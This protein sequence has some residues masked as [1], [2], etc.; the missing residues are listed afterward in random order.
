MNST[1]IH[2]SVTQVFIPMPIKIGEIF[3]KS[4]RPKYTH[5]LHT[6]NESEIRKLRKD[7][8]ESVAKIKRIEDIINEKNSVE[9]EIKLC[10]DK[11]EAFEN[12]IKT[13]EKKLLKNEE[14]IENLLKKNDYEERNSLK[15]KI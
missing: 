13:L 1:M 11:L 8:L 3:S 15:K 14:K 10:N 2:L 7:H 12:Q 9:N 5:I 6:S 4:P